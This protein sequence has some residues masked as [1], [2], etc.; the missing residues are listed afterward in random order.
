MDI[1]V[2]VKNSVSVWILILCSIIL[3]AVL[4]ERIWSINKAKKMPR[5]L[6]RRIESIIKRGNRAEAYDT[7]DD[8]DSPFSRVLKAGI[9]NRDNATEDEVSE[10]LSLAC[11]EEVS[12]LSR[13]VGVLGTMG[14]IAPFIGLFGTVIGIIN[15][16][17]GVAKQGVGGE[18]VYIGIS[19]AL[20]ATAFGLII[21][22]IAV[23][24][25][26]WLLSAIDGIRINLEKYATEWSHRL[27]HIQTKDQIQGDTE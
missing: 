13:P 6:M 15:A 7:L 4:L 3:L 8:I 27:K 22:I 26:N 5:D 17:H 21:G 23:V 20:I 11:D 12:T 9:L 18:A 2:I 10:M 25:N 16:F 24:T 1:V 19:E 14:N